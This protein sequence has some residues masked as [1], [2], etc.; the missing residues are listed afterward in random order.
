MRICG[1]SINTDV[2]FEQL[3]IKDYLFAKNPKK[4]A[5]SELSYIQKCRTMRKLS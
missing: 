2:A 3:E 1:V 4:F 5:R